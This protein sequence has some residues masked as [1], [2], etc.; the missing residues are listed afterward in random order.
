MSSAAKSS[1]STQAMTPIMM[2]KKASSKWSAN[3]NASPL[4]TRPMLK[5]KSNHVKLL[6]NLAAVPPRPTT[7]LDHANSVIA[8]TPKQKTNNTS[9]R[10][11]RNNRK[12]LLSNTVTKQHASTALTV[13]HLMYSGHQ[14]KTQTTT[15][16]T[17]TLESD[18]TMTLP[19]QGNN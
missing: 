2:Q 16:N 5:F 17:S 8:Q 12:F 1:S 15:N 18:A 13:E 19:L 11:S 14:T 9:S 6:S 7:T 4:S 3:N 10:K